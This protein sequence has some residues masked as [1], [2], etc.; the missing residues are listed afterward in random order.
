MI[1]SL[2]ERAVNKKQK[3][4]KV[5]NEKKLESVVSRGSLAEWCK[6]SKV[7]GT[8]GSPKTR[9]YRPAGP[10]EQNEKTKKKS[11]GHLPFQQH[12]VD[13]SQLIT[14]V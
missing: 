6:G 2:V 7:Q 14:E 13:I 5:R 12:E 10:T 11:K 1:K 9:C 3:E 4:T 8:R